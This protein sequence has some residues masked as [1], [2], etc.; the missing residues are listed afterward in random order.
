V[1]KR[2]NECEKLLAKEKTV[3]DPSELEK[4][5]EE[6]LYIDFRDYSAIQNW[7]DRSFIALDPFSEERHRLEPV[8][9]SGFASPEEKI[10]KVLEIL[11]DVA[12]RQ[13]YPRPEPLCNVNCE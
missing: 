9:P 13:K 1:A 6:G 5:I 4:L 8:C 12:D 7:L 10:E 2:R 11:N 3:E